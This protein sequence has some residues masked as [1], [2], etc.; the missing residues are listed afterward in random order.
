MTSKRTT[1]RKPTPKLKF[2][3]S[4][5]PTGFTPVE[6]ASFNDMQ[7]A[8]VVRELIQNSLDAAA[9]AG[10]DTAIVRF[11]I[12]SMTTR[13]VPDL[14]GYRKAFRESVKFNS[15]SNGKLP[16]AATEVVERINK[17][18][19]EISNRDALIVSDNG[20]GLDPARMTKLMS[21]GATSKGESGTGSYGGGHFAVIPTSDLRYVLYAGVN[22][23]YGKN[24]LW[25]GDFGEQAGWQGFPIPIWT[26]WILGKKTAQRQRR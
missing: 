24:R 3:V 15:D 19:S 11:K 25:H 8:R 2:G 10:R 9:E 16:D 26:I 20:I 1:R 14:S 23:E 22:L 7:P 17:A 4:S 13:N 6:M 18:L 12:A 5:T 21:N